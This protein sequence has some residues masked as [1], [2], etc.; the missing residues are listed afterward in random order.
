MKNSFLTGAL[1]LVIGQGAAAASSSFPAELVKT[2]SLAVQAREGA[3]GKEYSVLPTQ[4]DSYGGDFVTASAFLEGGRESIRVVLYSA[5]GARELVLPWFEFSRVL[6]TE[7]SVWFLAGDRLREFN[8]ADGRLL[9]EYPSYPGTFEPG[10][11]TRARGFTQS[12]GYLYI[13]HGELGVVVFDARAHRHFT[14]LRQGLRPGSLAAAV[15]V[16]GSELFVLQGA[17]H[18]DGFNGVAVVNLA[19][20]AAHWVSYPA[21]SGVVDPYSSSMKVVG[22]HLVINNG[23]WIHGYRLVDLQNGPATLAPSWLQVFEAIDTAGGNMDKYLMIE[24]DFVVSGEELLACSAISY[25]PVGQRRPVREW[26]LIRKKV[27]FKLTPSIGA[28]ITEKI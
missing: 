25:V 10:V 5:E 4:M 23:G 1:L 12:G 26:R 3:Y 9:G 15:Q 7:S 14:V 28:H 6:L 16:V 2:C 11:T 24:G 17:Y 13:A 21:S 19:Q 18:P 27:E 22:P 8:R 20:G